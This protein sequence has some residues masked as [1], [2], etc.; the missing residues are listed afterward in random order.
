MWYRRTFTVPAEWA[1]E[2]VL[3]NFG[4]VD[5][6]ATV[7]VNGQ[8][9]GSHR[10]GYDAFSL[11]ITG[12]LNGGLNELI[13][14][15]YDPTNAANPP[16]GKQR[17]NPT[18]IWYTAASGI[19]QTVW[20]EPVPAAFITRLQLTPDLDRQAVHL[21]VRARPPLTIE[22]RWRAG[23]LVARATA[24]VHHH[25]ILRTSVVAG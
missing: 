20:L 24:R 14:N 3:L 4:A 1:G 22:A 9:A 19:W 25:A 10:G 2:R 18:G 8:T 7:Y 13:V 23:T 6:E 21:L 16:L 12:H 11:D 17:L 15:V 5:W